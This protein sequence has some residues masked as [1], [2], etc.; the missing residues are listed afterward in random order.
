[1]TFDPTNMA[2]I[3]QALLMLGYAGCFFNGLSFGL[4]MA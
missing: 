4:R 1:M 2:H 3:G